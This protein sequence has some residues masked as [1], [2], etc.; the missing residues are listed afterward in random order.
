MDWLQAQKS[1][2]TELLP[3]YG[4]REAAIITDWVLEN[5]SGWKKIDRIL[6]RSDPLSPETLAAYQRYTQELLSHRPVQYV[7]HESWF[8]GMKLYVDENVLIPRP[9][10]EELVEWVLADTSSSPHSSPAGTHT[11]LDV[12]TGSGCIAIALAKQLLTSE[13]HACDLS[14]N[15]LEV[16]RRN[17]TTQNTPVTF[18]E[19]DFLNPKT[20]QTF[21]PITCLVSNPP[22]IPQNEKALMA[23]HVTD[24]EPGQALFVPNDDALLFYRALSR[25]AREH[26]P[27]GSQLFVEIHEEMGEQVHHLFVSAGLNNVTL[28]QDLQGKDRMVKAT[29]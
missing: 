13:I 25:F 7:L 8:A 3:L 23:T 20:W 9:E 11:I 12:G 22:Y 15:A 4:D 26:M 18:H 27:G 6:H 28:R 24:F 1:L 19:V 17:A 29:T 16:A 14:P 10:T 2:T 21:P 5:L